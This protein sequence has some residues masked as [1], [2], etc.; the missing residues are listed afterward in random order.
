[1][2]MKRVPRLGIERAFVRLNRIIPADTSNCGR[3]PNDACI[4]RAAAGSQTLGTMERG[5]PARCCS[6]ASGGDC[7]PTQL[8]RQ[9]RVVST[10][11][12]SRS[13]NVAEDG[14]NDD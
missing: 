3:V 5:Q 11:A 1:M 2:Q 10:D 4:P 14:G 12:R 9:N 6:S 13:L 8:N 7:T